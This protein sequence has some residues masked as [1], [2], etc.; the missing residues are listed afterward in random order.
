MIKTKQELQILFDKIQSFYTDIS[1]LSNNSLSKL[2]RDILDLAHW[3]DLALKDQYPEKD[4]HSDLYHIKNAA[5][6]MINTSEVKKS[7]KMEY[8]K[9]TSFLYGYYFKDIAKLINK[10][11]DTDKTS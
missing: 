7:D 10:L 1:D 3:T 9:E 4:N 6:R 5:N 2:G 8:N 11:A